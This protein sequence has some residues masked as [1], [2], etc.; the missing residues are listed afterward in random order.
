ML[1]NL[2]AINVR[3]QHTQAFNETCGCGPCQYLLS[4]AWLVI[5][6]IVAFG[7]KRYSQMNKFKFMLV[8]NLSYQ[9]QQQATRDFSYSMAVAKDDSKDR[10]HL[11]SHIVNRENLKP[12]DHIYVYKACGLFTHHGIYTGYKGEY[13][14][15]HFEGDIDGCPLEEFLCGGKLR[16][17]AYE[18]PLTH[19]LFKRCG[20][21]HSISC[22]PARD[23]IQT[24]IYY[25][26]NP[27]EFGRYNCC[28]RN[29]Q[30]FAIHCKTGKNDVAQTMMSAYELRD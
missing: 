6:A 8:A 2:S 30:H 17:V 27:E 23:V 3:A 25:L 13:E 19:H 9:W 16:L 26:H 11:F 10:V 28:C 24:A 29:C 15:I 1:R 5:V 21:S 7:L 14:V 20:S 22:R 4:A 18:V 12:G